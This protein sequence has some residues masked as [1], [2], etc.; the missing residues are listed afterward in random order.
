[1]SKIIE[2]AEEYAKHYSRNR[3][4]LNTKAALVA[5]VQ[6]LEAANRDCVDHFNQ[7]REERDALAKDAARYRWLRDANNCQEGWWSEHADLLDLDELDAAIDAAIA[8]HKE[9]V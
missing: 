2:L 8:K 7:M 3:D 1:M 5:A 9:Q 4:E 6:D